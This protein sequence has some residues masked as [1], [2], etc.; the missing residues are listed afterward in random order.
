M[1]NRKL[2][3]AVVLMGV[4]SPCLNAQGR[5]TIA[6]FDYTGVPAEVMSSAVGMARRTFGLVG[7]ETVWVVCL[8]GQAWPEGCN[9]PV[10]LG[11][12]VNMNVMPKMGAKAH[13]AGSALVG[14]GAPRV[15]ASYATVKNLGEITDR[16][17]WLALGCVMTHEIAHLLGLQHRDRGVMR[18]ALSPRQLDEARQGLG[19]TGADAKQLREGV[20]RLTGAL[21]VAEAGLR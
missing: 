13:L 15:Y 20:R 19:F 2:M 7:I 14:P 12:H 8:F 11:P 10:P 3:V 21:G 6:V 5:L 4:G 17:V 18:A 1:K 16:P 9:Q